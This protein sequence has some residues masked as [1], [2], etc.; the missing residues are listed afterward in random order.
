MWSFAVSCLSWR[1]GM[2]NQASM[3]CRT[4]VERLGCGAPARRRIWQAET[5]VH[6][7]VVG[8][9]LSLPEQR[10]ICRKMEPA[11][12][13]K[14]DFYVHELVVANLG[15][16]NQLSREVDALLA[17]KHAVKAKRFLTM[18][19]E[20]YLEAWRKSLQRGDVC[21][22]LWCAA[23]RSD[24]SHAARVEIFGSL[25]VGLHEFAKKYPQHAAQLDAMSSKIRLAKSQ[26]AEACRQGR[27]QG[28]EVALLLRRVADTESSLRR[29][30]N[31]VAALT[32][33]LAEL[34]DGKEFARLLEKNAVLEAQALRLAGDLGRREQEVELLRMRCHERESEHK[35]SR[36][37]FSD[38]LQVAL[39]RA[40]GMTC[41]SE[42]CS[43]ECPSFDLCRKR[44]LIV[45]GLSRMEDSYRRF[46]EGRGGI[47]EYHDGRLH[48]GVKGLENSFKRADVVL[49]P[50]NCNSHG[51]C[52]LVKSLG[53][54]HKKP[55]HMLA[56][57]G[58]S[59][60]SRAMAENAN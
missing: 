19:E 59:T 16:E 56:G 53:K 27:A 4:D 35:R 45:G 33:E 25:H 21:N 28:E 1:S 31:E 22:L 38:Q 8:M 37:K 55:V 14:S 6:C 32:F 60:V 46:V 57:F 2:K 23:V 41:A 30:R 9:C 51:A 40:E 49:C 26:L 24:L 44:V 15:Q 5:Y 54:K 58:L 39:P 42:T 17:R 3:F 29:S 13:A 43:P 36:A 50:V 20:E 34:R 10:R 48:G 7:P 12:A 18:P 47:F 52:L 11:C